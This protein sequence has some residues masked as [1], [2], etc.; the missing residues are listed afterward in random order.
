MKDAIDILLQDK[1][2]TDA[3][4]LLAFHHATPEFLPRVVAE[5]R[6]LQKQG[7]KAGGAK[8]L[9]H[10]LR[11]DGHW[12]AIDDFEIDDHLRPL[13]VRV[14]ALLWP[15]IKGMVQFCPCAADDILG[16]RIVRRGKGRGNFLYPGKN[17]VSAASFLP[18][19]KNGAGLVRP[20][21]LGGFPTVITIPPPVPV[22]DRPATFHG[23]ITEAEAASIAA[24]L[25]GFV[26]NSP[27]P[28]HPILLAWLR[29]VEAQPEI[30]AF[31]QKT[32]LERN[33]ER[34]SAYSLLEYAR[35]SIKR[36]AERHKRFTLPNNFGGLYS[37]ALIVLNLQFNGLCE[38]KEDSSGKVRPGRA[39]RLL[40]CSLASEPINGEPYRRLVWNRVTE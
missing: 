39:N 27:N 37:R 40:G 5:F 13:A 38:F 22:L 8:S 16:T 15:D 30:F 26:D 31:M 17:T 36:A 19:E 1:Q 32:L 34:F 2:H 7:R 21:R 3:Q 35:W 6:L 29:H 11:W 18:P 33:P 23:L 20:I 12:Q 25:R 14:C 9:F 4:K 10:F 24:P 28:R